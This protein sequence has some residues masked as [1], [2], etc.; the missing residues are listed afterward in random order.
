MKNGIAHS[1]PPATI[2]LIPNARL[3]LAFLE[4]HPP[5]MYPAERL[6]RKTPITLP[7]TTYT[8]LPKYGANTLTPKTSN[9]IT[10]QPQMHAITMIAGPLSLRPFAASAF[11]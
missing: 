5:N 4:S 6:R 10:N 1:H 9:S 3:L 11:L 7:I 2:R 8:A